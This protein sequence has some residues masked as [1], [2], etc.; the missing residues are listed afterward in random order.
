MSD[1][2]TKSP[3]N[4][5]AVANDKD[6]VELAGYNAYRNYANE[7]IMV[8]NGS[9]YRVVHT[10]Y[11]DPTGMDAITVQNIDTK[12][13]TIVYTG[14]GDKQ[15]VITD[16]KLLSDVPPVQLEHAVEYFN[17]MDEKYGIS[18]ICGNS[19]A[20]A[21]TNAVAIKNPDVKAVNLNPALLPA[22][23]ADPN[24]TYDNITNY[25]SKYDVLTKIE[26]PL[27]FGDRIPGKQYK[28][29]NG[30][31]EV[32]HI[33][34]NHTG[35]KK[36]NGISSGNEGQFYTIGVKGQPGFGKIYMAADEHIVTSIWSAVPL[37]GGG[38]TERID[39]NPENLN[40]LATALQDRVIHKVSLVQDYLGNAAEIVKH[41]GDQFTLRV[42]H[43]QEIFVEFFE[44]AGGPLFKGIATTGN[45][46]NSHID[47]LISKLNAAE[48]Q[49]RFLNSILNS[50]PAELIEHITS[51]NVSVESLFGEV[52]NYLYSLKDK[53]NELTGATV[54]I[55]QEKI[56]QLFEGGKELFVDAVVDELQAHF[57]IINGNKD[58]VLNQLKEYQ[59]QVHD[60]ATNFEHQDQALGQSI[61][62]NTG[63]V[64]GKV[65]IQP[66]NI[67]S[68]EKSPYLLEKMRLKDIHLD[69]SFEEF[70]T[71]THA[72]FI[73][74]LIGIKRLLATIVGTLETLSGLVKG[75]TNIALYG[76]VS[77]ALISIFTDFD[78]KVKSSVANT[79]Q[80][81]DELVSNI[82][83]IR[84]G[85]DSLI[86]NYPDLLTNFKPYVNDAL[87]NEGGYD[88]VQL[89][90]TA[91]TSILSEMEML[92]Q[93]IVYQ[94]SDHKA[95]SIVALRKVSESALGNMNLLHQQVNRGTMS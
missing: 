88:N 23:M 69:T 16:V 38:Q 36:G 91:A 80:P 28:I 22:G 29:N 50:P 54:H 6:L 4:N 94:L 41:E 3:K 82:E 1:P 30:V 40:M 39:I 79:L 68:I 45:I 17:K 89:Y 26:V 42:N 19:L 60:V 92:F 93:D 13:Y 73:M 87:F 90:N 56:P 75:A 46:L 48:D 77:G 43:L 15:D 53:V 70:A 62:G 64:N 18:S 61:G 10:N 81:L 58:K 11:T 12:S 67:Y 72:V 83:G 44:W 21:Y 37:Y 25:F 65:T 24:K 66:T 47:T 95:D 33:T 59:T 63:D 52:R 34:T 49:C 86:M 51:T 55:L 78:D 35:Y 74:P 85:V 20:G 76:N 8:V 5:Q 14:T 57:Q 31:P 27:E 71:I 7:Q 2:L 32:G 84:K 9:E